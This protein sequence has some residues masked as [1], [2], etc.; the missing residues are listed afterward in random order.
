MSE[1]E[2]IHPPVK[3]KSTDPLYMIYTSGTTGMPK[4]IV[5]DAGGT[6][7]ALT[8]AMKYIMNVGKGERYFAASDI[9][10]VVSHT[11][12]IYGPL[13]VGAS[14]IFYE[15]KPVGTPDSGIFF[16]LIE[17]Y[18]V[19]GIFLSPTAVRIIRK[20]DI[21]GKLIKKYDLSSLNMFSIAGER[22]D[23][24]SFTWI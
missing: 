18:K 5:R 21:E 7:V 2:E 1:T 24:V 4:G 16:K 9:G 22:S 23:V 17:K 11:F 12:T 3:V 10:W 19:K 13:L 8:W 14:T 20:E 15:G 6:A